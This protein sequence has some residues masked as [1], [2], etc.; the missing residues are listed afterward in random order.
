MNSE[1][2][3]IYSEMKEDEVFK[4][5]EELNFSN[6]RLEVLETDLFK[7]QTKIKKQDIEIRKLQEM[8]TIN[9]KVN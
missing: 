6:K 5:I 7:S 9:N 3:N 1:Q 4:L 8:I 2:R